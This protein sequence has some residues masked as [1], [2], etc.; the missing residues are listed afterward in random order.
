MFFSI[1]IIGH[2]KYTSL[3]K[4]YLRGASGIIILT[5][6]TKSSFLDSAFEWLEK[7][8]ENE[9]SMKQDNLPV[10]LFQNKVDLIEQEDELMDL[11]YINNVREIAKQKGFLDC[12]QVSTKSKYNLEEGIEFLVR[13]ILKLEKEED[14]FSETRVG[15]TIVNLDPSPKRLKSIKQQQSPKGN[16]LISSNQNKIPSRKPSCACLC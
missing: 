3:S 11:K 13:E 10:I 4:L 6:I 16:Q 5:D 9:D 8:K 7:F 1:S 12:F 2:D 14:K 15:D